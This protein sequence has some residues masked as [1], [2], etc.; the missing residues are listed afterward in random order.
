VRV[1]TKT[2]TLAP[3]LRRLLIVTPTGE[4]HAGTG[5]GGKRK[6]CG[7]RHRA[8]CDQIVEHDRARIEVTTH[9]ELVDALQHRVTEVFTAE[10]IHRAE[11]FTV[12]QVIHHAVI[13]SEP[14]RIHGVVG[15]TRRQAVVLPAGCSIPSL[16]TRNAA[17]TRELEDRVNTGDHV[18]S[19]ESRSPQA[20]DTL[21]RRRELLRDVHVD[22]NRGHLG[23][24][25]VLATLGVVERRGVGPA[26]I[27]CSTGLVDGQVKLAARNLEAS[28]R[29]AIG[30]PDVRSLRRAGSNRPTE[31]HRLNHPRLRD[32]RGEHQRCSKDTKEL[33]HLKPFHLIVRHMC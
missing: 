23:L 24:Q 1:Y 10:G 31:V 28:R 22:G 4:E 5:Q 3:L 26:A 15:K 19:S 29:I 13:Q 11:Q 30:V 7:L 33:F 21:V 2:R 25:V 6:T 9:L 14:E 27:R 17:V 12:Q 16:E 8:G 20:A 32:T 18:G